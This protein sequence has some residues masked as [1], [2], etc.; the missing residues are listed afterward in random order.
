MYL[1]G[2]YN[3]PLKDWITILSLST[4]F[5]F[6]K[7]RSQAIRELETPFRRTEM[8]PVN[9]IVL[10]QKFGIEEWLWEGYEA[11]C[12]RLVGLTDEEAEK[13]GAVTTNR[14]W[15]AREMLQKSSSDLTNQ[16]HENTSIW[17]ITTHDRGVVSSVLQQVFWP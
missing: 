14:L 4:R 16:D 5:K 8:D 15:R 6:D 3:P 11:L 7:V 13:V 1:W 12:H 9:R 10:A 17:D 2:H